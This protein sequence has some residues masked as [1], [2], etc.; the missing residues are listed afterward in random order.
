MTH[1]SDGSIRVRPRVGAAYSTLS[2]GAEVDFCDLGG[3]L[4][5]FRVW[6]RTD[7]TL[8]VTAPDGVALVL[9]ADAPSAFSL[10]REQS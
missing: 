1:F 3:D 10:R 2:Y 8:A 4:P 5:A 6:L 7:G 9:A